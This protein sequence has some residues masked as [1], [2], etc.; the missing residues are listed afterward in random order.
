MIRNHFQFKHPEF[1]TLASA[2]CFTKMLLTFVIQLIVYIELASF[3][4][5]LTLKTTRLFSYKTCK[6]NYRFCD[7]KILE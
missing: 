4:I 7:A 3:Q 1:S 5:C 6:L 2:T